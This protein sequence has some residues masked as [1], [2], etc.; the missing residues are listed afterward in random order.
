MKTSKIIDTFL[1]ATLSGIMIGMGGIVYLSCQNKYLGAFLFSI[2]LTTILINRTALFTGKVGY[3]LYKGRT[4]LVELLIIWLGNFMG[5]FI[6]AKLVSFTRLSRSLV[7][8][9]TPIVETKA[10]DGFV[11]LFLLAV[12]C[13]ILMNIAVST[14]LDT[15]HPAIVK[16]GVSSICVAVFILCGFEH[17]VANMFYFSLAGN[18]SV[19]LVLRLLVMTLGNGVGGNVIPAYKQAAKMLAH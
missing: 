13:G 16:L 11:S 14:Y 18:W 8:A 4:N 10:A 17:C 19:L 2:G 3:L 1:S 12:F 15:E 6:T 5:T 9:V 7:P